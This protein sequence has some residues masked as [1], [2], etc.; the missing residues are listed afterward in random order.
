MQIDW[1]EL[2]WY[3]PAAQNEQAVAPTDFVKEPAGQLEQLCP[4]VLD[5]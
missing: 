4:A 5:W 2:D 3:E 1:A